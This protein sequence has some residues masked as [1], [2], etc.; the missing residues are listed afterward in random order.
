MARGQAQSK[1]DFSLPTQT[2]GSQVAINNPHPLQGRGVVAHGHASVQVSACTGRPRRA[3]RR[4]TVNAVG[5]RA[6]AMINLKREAGPRCDRGGRINVPDGAS[7][8]L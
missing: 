7:Q 3:H 1:G 6:H 4:I 5:R 8:R 2:S